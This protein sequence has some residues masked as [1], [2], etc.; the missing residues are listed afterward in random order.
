MKEESM[1]KDLF[2]LQELESLLSGYW[3]TD[4]ANF[5]AFLFEKVPDVNWVGFYLSDGKKLRLAPFCGKPACFVIPFANGVCGHA[6]R[7]VETLVVDDVDLFAGHIRCDSNSKSEIVIPL[8]ISNRLVGVL[9]IDSPKVARFTG[10]DRIFLEKAVR[11]LSQ[12]ISNYSGT[13]FGR[14]S[15]S[16]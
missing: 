14:I 3:L 1:Q 4:L 12:K 7:Q 9:D 2:D 11:I 10:E 6:Y 15:L 13:K 16:H 5:S 8:L